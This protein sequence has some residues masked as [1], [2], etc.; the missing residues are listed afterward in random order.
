MTNIDSNQKWTLTPKRQKQLELEKKQ[1]KFEIFYDAPYKELKKALSKYIGNNSKVIDIGAYQGNLEDFL[2]NTGKNYDIKC[3][4][5]DVKAL[6][7]LK[8]KKYKNLKIT[9]V[10]SDAN[11]F[12][13]REAPNGNNDAIMLSATL[14]EINNIYDQN[15]YLNNF[16][17]KTKGLLNKN[18]II[19]IGD[20]YYPENVPKEEFEAFREY[21]KKAIDHADNRNKFINPE[22]IKTVSKEM[23]FVVEYFKE[24]RAVKEIDRR[25]Y[26]IVL[27]HINFA[28]S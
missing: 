24:I 15:G 25:Y 28:L 10:Q 12:I 18:G 19:I 8:A 11:E 16:M 23:G 4:D 1:S 14:H 22:L 21:Q 5:A 20:F 3:V 17:S 2:D 26:V 13:E 7:F 6:E 27:K 9:V